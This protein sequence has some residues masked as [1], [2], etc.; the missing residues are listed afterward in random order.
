MAELGEG[1]VPL[2]ALLRR[3]RR[4]VLQILTRSTQILKRELKTEQRRLPITNI[5]H[6]RRS[7]PGSEAGSPCGPHTAYRLPSRTRRARPTPQRYLEADELADL[8]AALPEH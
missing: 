6:A 8:I 7:Y 3:H 4:C 5:A 2:S 1:G